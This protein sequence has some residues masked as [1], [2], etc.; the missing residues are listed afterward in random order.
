MLQQ[1]LLGAGR[2]PP[3]IGSHT[4]GATTTSNAGATTYTSA[5]ESLVL[6][7]LYLASICAWDVNN[8]APSSISL[9]QRGQTWTQCGIEQNTSS[10]TV[11]VFQCIGASFAP[12]AMVF[13]LGASFSNIIFSLDTFTGINP[14]KP[15]PQNVPGMVFGTSLSISL[16]VLGN[17]SASFGAFALSGSGGNTLSDGT[18]Y[19]SLSAQ[20]LGA[21]PALHMIT[22]WKQAGSTTVNT[23]A[24]GG[25]GNSYFTGVGL[26]IA[27]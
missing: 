26:E 20:N 12:A 4:D 19:S 3:I 16:S 22:E 14:I 10:C 2:L 8:G 13:N 5:A 25:G 24:G 17:S 11:A 9:T 6:G 1:L 15:V 27:A 23:G 21:F 7:Q 18:G